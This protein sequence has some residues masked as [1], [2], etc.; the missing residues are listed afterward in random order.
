[1]EWLKKRLN[2]KLL[3]NKYVLTV[4]FFIVWMTFFDQHNWIDQWKFKSELNRKIQDKEYYKEEI[5]KTK[6][7]MEQILNDP[8]N[9]EKFARE[10]Y[11]MTKEGEVL[12]VITEEKDRQK[13]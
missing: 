9:L 12:F 10:K 13:D 6:F 1:M 5:E 2:R 8:N 11:Y 7:E 4:V 3:I